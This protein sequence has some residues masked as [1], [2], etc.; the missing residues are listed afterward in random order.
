MLSFK[1]R[2]LYEIVSAGITCPVYTL[3]NI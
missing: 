1:S 2:K 3:K